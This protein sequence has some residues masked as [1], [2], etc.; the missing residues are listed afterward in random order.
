MFKSVFGLQVAWFVF[1]LHEWIWVVFPMISASELLFIDLRVFW[2][3]IFLSRISSIRKTSTLQESMEVKEYAVNDVSVDLAPKAVSTYR[4]IEGW[5]CTCLTSTRYSPFFM[6]YILALQWL[7][8]ASSD[9]V[10]ASVSRRL[11]RLS[12]LRLVP[13]AVTPWR[14]W[15]CWLFTRHFALLAPFQ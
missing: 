3:W 5:T 8:F 2:G 7:L 1:K 11:S 9:S 6:R 10:S 13:L 12:G 4:S 15:P 14:G